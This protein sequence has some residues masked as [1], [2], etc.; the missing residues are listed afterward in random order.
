M[1]EVLWVGDCVIVVGNKNKV[2]ANIIDN[3]YVIVYARR[4]VRWILMV[5]CFKKNEKG[6]EE[7][8]TEHN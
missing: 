4:R 1:P 5:S 3:L 6:P 8:K 2:Y 7:L